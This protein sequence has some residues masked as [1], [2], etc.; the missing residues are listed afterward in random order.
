MGEEM[1]A[2]L[3]W[4]EAGEDVLTAEM[5]RAQALMEERIATDPGSLLGGEAN[6]TDVGFLVRPETILAFQRIIPEQALNGVGGSVDD[7][8]AFV[9]DWGFSLSSIRVPVLITYGDDD[10]S[11]PVAH[12]RFLSSAVPD[13]LVIE[14]T[15]GGHFA[16]DP[17]HDILETHRWLSTGEL[18]HA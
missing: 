15:G 11:L 5:T 12:G 3:A 1:A 17:I 7:A 16:D 10:T 14:T 4:V 9:T 6:E 2:E 18:P 8:L 13:A